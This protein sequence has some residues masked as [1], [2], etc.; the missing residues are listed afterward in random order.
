[1]FS[2]PLIVIEKKR[3]LSAHGCLRRHTLFSLEL[4]V[5]LFQSLEEKLYFRSNRWPGKEK[6]GKE[7]KTP[8]KVG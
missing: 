6:N 8:T 1:M 2:G 5:F 7:E 4:L 3:L